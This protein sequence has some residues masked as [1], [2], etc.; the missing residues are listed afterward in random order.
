MS[1]LIDYDVKNNGLLLQ[2]IE[3]PSEEL[4]I[5]ALEN[6][7]A[8]FSIIENK[9]KKICI[10]GLNKNPFLLR[11]IENQ[12]DELCQIAIKNNPF[13]IKH[14]INKTFE[15]CKLAFQYDIETRI[16]Y[17]EYNIEDLFNK[18]VYKNV[19]ENIIYNECIICRTCKD[20]YVYYKCNKHIICL[21]CSLKCSVCYFRCNQ[22]VSG[23]ILIK[24]IF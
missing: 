2:Y 4:C 12:D 1:S 22:N 16:Y 10:I 18:I 13:T 17:P 14:C 21:E 19:N 11:F 15:L 6:N 23:D 20:K 3:N 7:S 24:I 5:L 8:I 9:T